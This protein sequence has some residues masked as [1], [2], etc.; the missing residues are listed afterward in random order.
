MKLNFQS[1]SPLG[2][3]KTEKYKKPTKEQRQKKNEDG[4]ASQTILRPFQSLYTDFKIACAFF[5]R[6][7]GAYL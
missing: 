3:G 2:E 7:T 5:V 1:Y 6:I 4:G